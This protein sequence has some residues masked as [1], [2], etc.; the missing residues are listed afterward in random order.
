MSRPSSTTAPRSA[1]TTPL[2]AFSKRALA[3]A[4]RAEQGDDLAFFDVDVDTEQHL[5]AVVAGIEAAHQQQ[6]AL[7]VPALVQGLAARRRRP[8]HL[9]D[10][11]VDH[12]A[13]AAQ[14][15]AADHEQRNEHEHAPADS[16]DGRRSSR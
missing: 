4:V 8:P 5:T 11:G 15:E 6:V 9:G 7:A 14:D 16:D 12:R 13:G 10:V 3:G 1:S 2:I